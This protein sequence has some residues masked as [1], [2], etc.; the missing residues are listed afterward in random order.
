MPL[1]GIP[2]L[3]ART[4]RRPT[5]RRTAA[6]A[7][8]AAVR[9]SQACC[10]PTSACRWTRLTSGREPATI[11]PPHARLLQR[12]GGGGRREV[13]RASWRAFPSSGI[14]REPT[15]VRCSP[16]SSRWAWSSGPLQIPLERMP[17]RTLRAL[18][19]AGPAIRTSRAVV[20]ALNR[21]E[22]CRQA[23]ARAAGDVRRARMARWRLSSPHSPALTSTG[24]TRSPGEYVR[25]AHAGLRRV[26]THPR[27]SSA[28]NCSI[29]A[30]PALSL[31]LDSAPLVH[32]RNRAAVSIRARAIPSASA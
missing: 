19:G 32:R 17:E 28:R 25:G 11:A 2:P 1:D 7:G 21:L 5:A 4:R 15:R 27:S 22:S 3:A 13:S 20:A 16:R 18:I 8:A 10:R 14:Q 29:D 26:P 23:V 12:C 6:T 31:L 9:S 30:G 24:A